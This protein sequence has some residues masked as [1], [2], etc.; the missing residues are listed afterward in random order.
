MAVEERAA[1]LLP[2]QLPQGRA[3][4]RAGSLLPGFLPLVIPTAPHARLNDSAETFV[5]VSLPH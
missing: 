5:S 4:G 1:Q 2:E 3:R